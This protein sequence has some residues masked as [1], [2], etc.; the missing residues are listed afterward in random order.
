MMSPIDEM[1]RSLIAVSTGIPIDDVVV[2]RLGKLGGSETSPPHL[3]GDVFERIAV[4]TSISAASGACAL[5]D[6]TLPAGNL[7]RRRLR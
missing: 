6:W 5:A 7:R 4:Q 3:I 2:K 1:A